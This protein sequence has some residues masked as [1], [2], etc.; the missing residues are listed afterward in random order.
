[1]PPSFRFAHVP[2]VHRA[3]SSWVTDSL[4]TSDA[5]QIPGQGGGEKIAKHNVRLQLSRGVHR[6]E[7]GSAASIV[8]YKGHLC[9]FYNFSPGLRE[10]VVPSVFLVILL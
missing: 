9:P 5:V 10:D 8:T 3:R 4:T 7:V 6:T 1:M 2:T